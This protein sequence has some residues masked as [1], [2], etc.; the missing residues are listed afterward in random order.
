MGHSFVTAL[1]E[2]LTK[3]YRL[4]PGLETD[5]KEGRISLLQ[6]GIWTRQVDKTLLELAGQLYNVTSRH[7]LDIM[8]DKFRLMSHLSEVTLGR[9]RG[10]YRS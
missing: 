5:V 2:E 9:C 1:S 3:Y 8:Y 4:L 6:L 7:V 10:G